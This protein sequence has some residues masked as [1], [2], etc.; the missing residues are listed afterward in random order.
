MDLSRII[1]LRVT[2]ALLADPSY[3]ARVRVDQDRGTVCWPNGADLD[4]MSSMGSLV[5]D[6][7]SLTASPMA[8]RLCRA[9]ITFA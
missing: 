3:F 5:P 4:P 9:N 6:A 2:F 8:R 7:D 1:S